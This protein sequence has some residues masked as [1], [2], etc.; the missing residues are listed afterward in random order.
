LRKRLQTILFAEKHIDD[1][2]RV[3]VEET[4]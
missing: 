3:E 2:C 4:Y 1:L